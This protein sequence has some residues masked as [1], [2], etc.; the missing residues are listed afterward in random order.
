MNEPKTNPY[1][2][3]PL[4]LASASPRRGKIFE[5]LGLNFC[6]QKA[7]VEESLCE[8]FSE[9]RPK[10]L[11]RE[12]ALAV[13]K[14]YSG[15]PV[16]GFDTLVFFRGKILGKPSSKKEAFSILS[17]LNGNT[18]RVISGV[19][20]AWNGEAIFSEDDTTE[21]TFRKLSEKA[22]LNY[23]DS[24]EPMDKAG[25]YGIQGLGAGLVQS[26]SG[27]YYN[28]VGVPLAKTLTILKDFEESY[29]RK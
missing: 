20:L 15:I 11:A 29:D 17:E 26:I 18:H 6:V 27:C 16:L 7:E 24:L 28:V 2:S 3:S 12:K 5:Q 1:F 25:A 13:S 19:S 8:D 14:N 10:T 23:I 22:I 21:V 9:S 4:V